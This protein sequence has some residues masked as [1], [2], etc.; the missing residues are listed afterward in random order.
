VSDAENRAAPRFTTLIRSAKIISSCGEYLCVLRDVSS[1]GIKVRLFHPLPTESRLIL[2]LANGERYPVERV[3]ERDDYAGLRFSGQVSVE[4]LLNEDGPMP[5][6]PVRLKMEL[7]ALISINGETTPAI[8]RDLSQQGAR[9][10]TSA[11]LAMDQ[12]LRLEV[13]G[14]PTIYAKV[15]WRRHPNAGLVFEQTFKL[16]ELARLAATLQPTTPDIE[17]E[18][19]RAERN[20][21]GTLG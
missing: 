18:Q 20:G 15:R 2:E 3:W 4:H 21:T 12:Q 9:I 14:L 17:P 6:R 5:K 7:P 1:T 19:F 10:E 11:Q 8:V 13:H 16:D